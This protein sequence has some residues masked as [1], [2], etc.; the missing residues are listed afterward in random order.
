MLLPCFFRSTDKIKCH[1]DNSTRQRLLWYQAAGA[2]PK[3]WQLKIWS[4]K[5]LTAALA[6]EPEDWPALLHLNPDFREH[7]VSYMTAKYQ[8]LA[9]FGGIFVDWHLKP[10]GQRG[11][12]TQLMAAIDR[13]KERHGFWCLD[14][15]PGRLRSI[16]G[17]VVLGAAFHPVLQHMGIEIKM[18]AMERNDAQISMSK[19]ELYILN[20]YYREWSGEDLTCER[21]N[22]TVNRHH[23]VT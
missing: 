8:I 6:S 4:P 14:P 18:Q 22:F 9:Y 20:Q 3:G 13:A 5:A 23:V 17:A 11:A 16:A 15:G 10:S 7:R 1:N 12:L 2:W 21:A 19:T